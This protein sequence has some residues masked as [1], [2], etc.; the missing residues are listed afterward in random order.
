MEE[1]FI[2]LDDESLGK[3]TYHEQHFFCAECGD[4]FLAPKQVRKT[5]Q[6]DNGMLEVLDQDDEVG[7]TVY[8]GHPYCEACHVRLRMPK[9][10]RCKKSIRPGDQ[11][12]EALGAKWCW[13]CFTCNVRTALCPALTLC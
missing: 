3:R 8:K 5:R 13:H 1:H 7:F 9:C 12:I 10:K 11:A 2:T 4:P 6:L